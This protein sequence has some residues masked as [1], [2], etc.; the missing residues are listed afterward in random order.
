MDLPLFLHQGS[1]SFILPT[2]I[3]HSETVQEHGHGPAMCPLQEV[4]V[5][6]LPE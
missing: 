6:I 5:R 2:V 1:Y 3:E 4:G